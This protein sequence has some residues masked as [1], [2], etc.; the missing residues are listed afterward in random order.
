MTTRRANRSIAIL[1][2]AMLLGSAESNRGIAHPLSQIAIRA[3]IQTNR[4]TVTMDIKLE[5]L[6]WFQD[7]KTADDGRISAAELKAAAGKHPEFLLKYFTILDDRGHRLPGTFQSIDTSRIPTA[8]AT[9]EELTILDITYRF[10]FPLSQLPGFVTLVQ[11]FRGDQATVPSMMEIDVSHNGLR[12]EQPVNL[13]EG[14]P[15]SF[16]LDWINGPPPAPRSLAELRKQK[17]QRRIRTLGMPN[18]NDVYSWFHA[19]ARSLRHYLV[20]PAWK[21]AVWTLLKRRRT[22][23]LEFSEQTAARFAIRRFLKQ[24]TSTETTA[25]VLAPEQIHIRFHDFSKQEFD[26]PV[27]TRTLHLSQTRI[28]IL[29]D[30]PTPKGERLQIKWDQFDKATPFLKSSI[31]FTDEPAKPL[32]FT[33]QNPQLQIQLPSLAVPPPVATIKSPDNSREVRLPPGVVNR[34]VNKETRIRKLELHEPRMSGNPFSLKQS[35]TGMATLRSVTSHWGHEHHTTSKAPAELVINKDTGN[36]ELLDFQL[37]E[38]R[39]VESKVFVPNAVQV[40][41]IR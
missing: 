40:S 10:Q 12:L 38:P 13:A 14:V 5:D 30:Y 16:S 25:G 4:I 21:M 11:H 32:Y 24:H 19:D 27:D 39:Q 22:N 34:L 28:G 18:Q 15:Y 2:F 17:E 35:V 6:V 8:G 41:F 37:N 3:D 29:L 33:A 20:I 9:A 36:W 7:L 1:M 26:G 23:W 31:R